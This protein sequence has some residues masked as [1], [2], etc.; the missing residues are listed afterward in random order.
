MLL[1]D[2]YTFYIE[3]IPGG[4]LKKVIALRGKCNI[5]TYNKD[6]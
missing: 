2:S 4:A 5:S 6:I 1:S 3:E